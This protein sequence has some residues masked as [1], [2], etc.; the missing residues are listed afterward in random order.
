FSHRLLRAA[1][2]TAVAAMLRPTELCPR[3]LSRPERVLR[4]RDVIWPTAARDHF[5]LSLSITKCDQFGEGATVHVAWP[6]AVAAMRDYL[7]G[8]PQALPNDPLF[9]FQDGG[10]LSAN[11]LRRLSEKLLRR[12]GVDTSQYR[13]LSFRAGG[14]TS[15]AA[16][17]VN[18]GLIKQLGRWR[19]NQYLRYVDTPASALNAASRR[20]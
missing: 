11:A 17:G 12:C 1:V 2:S 15:M 19:S 3:V 14:A 7:R 20:L 16:A 4:V 10:L 8:R 6:F 18:H 5:V 9:V 13:G